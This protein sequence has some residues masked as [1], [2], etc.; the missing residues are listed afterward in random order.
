MRIMLLFLAILLVYF[1]CKNNLFYMFIL[2]FRADYLTNNLEYYKV[3]LVKWV[4]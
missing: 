4:L 3:V 2:F 1:D